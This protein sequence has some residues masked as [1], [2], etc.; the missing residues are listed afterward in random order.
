MCQYKSIESQLRTVFQGNITPTE[1][2]SGIDKK[3]C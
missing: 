3:K 2:N 1:Q